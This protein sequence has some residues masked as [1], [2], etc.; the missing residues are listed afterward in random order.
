[1][2]TL[3]AGPDGNRIVGAEYD[4]ADAAEAQALID[5]GFAEEVKPAEPT[6]EAAEVTEVSEVKE[7]EPEVEVAT[8]P[9]PENAAARV[10]PLRKRRRKG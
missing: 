1:M 6:A 10:K 3:S 9:E 2:K 8:K 4:I 7:A 5:G